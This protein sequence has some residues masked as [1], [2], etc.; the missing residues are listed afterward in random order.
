MT[1]SR[2]LTLLM[3]SS[4]MVSVA[5]I[6]EEGWVE[7]SPVP[8][9][10]GTTETLAPAPSAQT[11][12]QTPEERKYYFLFFFREQNSQ[13]DSMWKVFQAAMTQAGDRANWKAVNLN[14]PASQSLVQTYNLGNPVTPLV[15]S[16][17]P[18]GAIMGVFPE[19]FTQEQLLA[20]FGTPG[21]EA[22]QKSLIQGKMVLL[23]LQ[24]DQTQFNQQALSGVQSFITDPRFNNY[25][26]AV[27]ID[28]SDPAEA[29]FMQNLNI[30]P[31]SR[32]A[33]TVMMTPPGVP[34]S[35]F[36][37]GTTKNSFVNELKMEGGCGADCKC[38]ES[39]PAGGDSKPVLS[40][41]FSK[42][43]GKF[44]NSG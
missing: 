42:I 20:S 24:N 9:N 34:V 7:S 41:F 25:A 5:A 4:L 28:P 17:A 8:E 18:N 36:T 43:S 32:T 37:G 39:V 22:C 14:D 35:T 12:A 15:L 31:N 27:K 3:A 10:Q 21:Q 6:A 44:R 33:M 23:C 11:S 38:L 2:V 1:L 16:I 26:E 13:T 40:K 30:D 19:T 29:P